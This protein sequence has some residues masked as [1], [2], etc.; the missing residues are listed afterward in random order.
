[1]RR[2]ELEHI[3]RACGRIT[4]QYEFVVVGSQSILGSVSNPPPD[5][6]ASMEA[7]IYPREAPELS[8][9]IDGAIGEGSQFH[10]EFGYYAQGVGPETAV[11]PSDW[12]DRAHR[13]QN[14]NT[15][16]KIGW[17]LD[18][19]DLFLAKAVA[20]RP[21]KDRDFCLALIA[22]ALVKPSSALAL[23][24]NMPLDD[25]E[26]KALRARIR[27]WVKDLRDSGVEVPE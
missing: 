9:N 27:R 11:L 21:P 24:E 5:F 26:R 7:D 15:D 19:V 10:D 12:M 17:C 3:I 8:D 16:L 2:E 13:I 4:G 20:N 6:T 23:V 18:T 25:A 1:M 22:H 14:E